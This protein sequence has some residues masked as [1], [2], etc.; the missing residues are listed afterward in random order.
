MNQQSQAKQYA[1]FTTVTCLDWKHVLKDDRFKDI[2]IESLSFLSA[3]ARVNIFAFV[4]MSNHLHLLWQMRGDTKRADVQRDFLRYTSQQILK[5]LRTEESRILAEL[6]V[7]TKDRK[8]QVWERNA[9]SIALWSAPVIDQKLEY[10]HY[11][12]VKAG[13]HKFPW[14]YIYSSAAFYFKSDRRWSFLIHCDG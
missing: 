9:L 2:I 4:I 3:S 12:P 1:E 8:Y 13:L 7:Q 14:E 6:L 10:I 11:N 5:I